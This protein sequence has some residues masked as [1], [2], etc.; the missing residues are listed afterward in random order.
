[1]VAGTWALHEIQI[2]THKQNLRWAGSILFVNFDQRV[3]AAL[4]IRLSEVPV[5]V[6]LPKDARITFVSEDERVR[7]ELVVDDR[8]V[9]D[10][11]VILDEGH[12]GLGATPRQDSAFGQSSQTESVTVAQVAQT[13]A[14][15]K[16]KCADRIVRPRVR[17][18]EPIV[19][20]A[21]AVPAFADRIRLD[22]GAA[23]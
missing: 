15:R 20:C 3:G 14:Q 8:T 12:G 1:L 2:V 13:P 16:I 7:K 10:H 22:T 17:F 18:V 4:S 9:A 19:D 5:E 23:T 21:F 11:V 6:I